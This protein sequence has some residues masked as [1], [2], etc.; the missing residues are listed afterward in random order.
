MVRDSSSGGVVE[1]GTGSWSAVETSGGSR[2][3]FERRLREE[4]GRSEARPRMPGTAVARVATA[5]IMALCGGWIPDHAAA[6]SCSEPAPLRVAFER[7]TVVAEVSLVEV[8]RMAD[9]PPDPVGQWSR[10][11][12]ERIFKGPR[13]L[14][15]GEQIWIPADWFNTTPYPAEMEGLELMVI[16]Y[17]FPI[18]RRWYR[19]ICGYGFAASSIPAYLHAARRERRRP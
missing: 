2:H 9:S 7:A 14:H 13:W 4:T 3:G 11:R 15:E 12:F 18:S 19:P 8:E 17:D 6:L 1:I 10:V 5:V 16:F